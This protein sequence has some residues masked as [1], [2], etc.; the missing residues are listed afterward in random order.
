M[1]ILGILSGFY[2][3]AVLNVIA[4]NK[5]YALFA[6]DTFLHRK[7]YMLKPLD[8]YF[9]TLIRK[10]TQRGWRWEEVM[11]PEDH[12]TTTAIQPI[13]RLGDR[14][15]W[16][17]SLSTQDVE[18]PRQPDLVLEYSFF[19]LRS[20]RTR[21]RPATVSYLLS[22]EPFRHI[23]LDYRFV[24]P[25]RHRTWLFFLEDR[26]CAYANLGLL[27]MKPE[28]R[29]AWFDRLISLDPL[30]YDQKTMDEFQRPEGWTTF[31]GDIPRWYDQW[32]S[33]L[34]PKL[35]EFKPAPEDQPY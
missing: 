16:M 6:R 34:D 5:A 9:E 18:T 7:T 4:W 15:T 21:S 3:T 17:V 2:T 23:T 31:D 25:G 13:R 12:S 24:R 30:L 8:P 29:P 27:A 32:Y 20:R 10:Y 1:P 19:S 28:D 14:F 33:R 22:A 11:R 26:L 35:K